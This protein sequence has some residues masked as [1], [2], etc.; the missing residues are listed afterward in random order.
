M[1]DPQALHLPRYALRRRSPRRRDRDHRL[2]IICPHAPDAAVSGDFLYA[3]VS[4]KYWCF[5]AGAPRPRTP[6]QGFHLATREKCIR[7]FP[8][9]L[10]ICCGNGLT[11][12]CFL[13]A[14]NSR[15]PRSAEECGKAPLSFVASATANPAPLTRLFCRVRDLVFAMGHVTRFGTLS[16]PSACTLWAAVCRCLWC[17]GAAVIPSAV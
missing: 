9:I 8:Q 5:F 11:A 12:N 14:K 6:R 1:D 10:L 2:T 15:P 7:I 16:A 3:I 17:W 4:C 13:P